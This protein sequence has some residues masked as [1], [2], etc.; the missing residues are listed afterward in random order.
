MKGVIKNFVSDKGFGFIYGENGEVFFHISEITTKGIIPEPGMEVEFLQATNA[1][2]DYAYNIKLTVNTKPIFIRIGDTRIKL[3]N[4]KDYGIADGSEEILEEAEDLQYDLKSVYAIP[5]PARA[6]YYFDNEYSQ[7]QTNLEKYTSTKR[8]KRAKKGEA[9][10][11]Y[12]T[13]Y[14]GDNYQFYECEVDWNI[15]HKL[16]ELDNYLCP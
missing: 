7:K 6:Q 3:S 10:Y 16:E 14:Q 8:Y 15:Y 5:I 11:L 9:K 13:T 1:K 12:I 2:G 4:I